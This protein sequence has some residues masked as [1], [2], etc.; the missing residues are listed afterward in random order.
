MRTD[1]I[2]V[3]VPVYNIPSD[4]LKKCLDSLNNQT[5]HN[6]EIIVVDDGSTEKETVN[7]CNKYKDN[8]KFKI[9]HKKNGGLCDARNFGFLHSKGDW[10]TF[11]DGDDSLTNECIDEVVKTLSDD[12]DILCFGTVKEYNNSKFNY[13]YDGLLNDGDI[14]TENEELLKLLLNFNSNIGDVT[15]KVYKKSFLQK[16]NLLHDKNIKQGVEAID[17]NFRCFDKCNCLKFSKIYGYIYAYNP[18]SITLS[19][20]EKNIDYLSRG[21]R[22]LYDDLLQSNRINLISEL[23]T[24]IN[25]VVVTTVV[26]G[27]FSNS[28]N[29][30][31]KHRIYL[32][33]LFMNNELIIKAINNNNVHLDLLR[34]IVIILIKKKRYSLLT[35]ISRFR[36]YQKNK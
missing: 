14:Y 10:I 24:R 23:D 3:I 7:L 15:A 25:Y 19:I 22:K 20:S 29:Y 33:N 28:N 21:I 36:S 26:S 2:S 31:K 13:T 11:V 6:I 30:S 16:Y 17:F 1:L 9:F 34:R 5:Y 12:V 8:N 27:I 32:F 35:I 18:N 4:M